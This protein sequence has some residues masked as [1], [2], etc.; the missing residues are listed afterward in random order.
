[1]DI[2]IGILVGAF[3]YL[4]IAL[5]LVFCWDGTIYTSETHETITEYH[6]IPTNKEA[7]RG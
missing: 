1:M 3:I 6:G 5:P 4:L 2:L 7:D